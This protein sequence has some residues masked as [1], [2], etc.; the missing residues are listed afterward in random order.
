MRERVV[1]VRLQGGLG[2]QLFEYAAGRFVANRDGATLLVQRAN[3]AGLNLFD[4]L[5]AESCVEAP[6]EV[7]RRFRLSEPGMSSVRRVANA[8]LREAPWRK[9]RY[10]IVREGFGGD[11]RRPGDVTATNNMLVGWFINVEWFES[12][13]AAVCRELLETLTP[14]PAYQLARDATVVSFRRG[15]FVRWGLALGSE[16]YEGAVQALADR[17]GPCFVIGDDDMFCD[18]AIDWLRKHGLDAQRRPSV[19]GSTGI[20]D[21]VLLAGARQVIMSN[22]TFCWWGTTSGD[23]SR[24]EGRLVIA[25]TPWNRMRE[26]EGDAREYIEYAPLQWTR[27]PATFTSGPA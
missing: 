4:V 26:R 24:P 25:P 1:V 14:H 18:F 2:N 22:S 5:P 13:F 9:A 10:G 23:L 16:Y 17:G 27:I 15:D 12:T 11:H 21:L 3:E 19:A 20:T 6:P 7:R 8:A